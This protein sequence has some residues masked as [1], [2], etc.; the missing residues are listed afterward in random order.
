MSYD[1]AVML[2][3]IDSVLE[4]A[5][6]QGNARPSADQFRNMGEAFVTQQVTRIIAVTDRLTPEGSA[7]RA[8]V[9]EPF[10][11]G[12]GADNP[13]VLPDLIGV[14][15][16]LRADVEAGYTKSVEELIHADVFADFLEMAGELHDKGYKDPAAVIA[17]SVLEEHLRKL[18]SNSGVTVSDSGGRPVKADKLN[19][20]LARLNVYNKLEQKNITAW[21]D[22][23]NKAAHGKYGE[24]DDAQ[25]AALIRDVRDFMIR[26]PA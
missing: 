22:L 3:Q 18:A 4:A 16:A 7:Y 20:D 10:G 2:A 1:T 6:V 14:L 12:F 17:G 13:H 25:V 11:R 19:S 15:Q 8:Q 23:R 9:R 26:H 21:L 24:Y 5:L